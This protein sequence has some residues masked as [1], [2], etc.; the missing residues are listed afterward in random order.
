M[1]PHLP[2]LTISCAL[3][4][5]LVLWCGMAL[6]FETEE[7]LSYEPNV[8]CIKGSPYGK[9]L[10]LALQGPIDLY[11]H[12]GTTHE[13][14]TILGD[15][16]E[17]HH[18]HH[19]HEYHADDHDHGHHADNH[20]HGH[21][22]HAGCADDCDHGHDHAIAMQSEDQG[23][24]L[25]EWSKQKIKELE[26][27][28]HR[29]TDGKSLSLAHERYLQEETEAKL[30]LAYELDPAN[31]TNYANYHFFLSTNIGRNEG[32]QAASL[33]LA[34]KTLAY[35]KQDMFDPASWVTASSAAYNVAQHIYDHHDQYEIA[36]AKASL[37]EIDYC[38]RQY[39]CMLA[40]AGAEG[41]SVSASRLSQMNERMHFLAKLRKALG[42]YMKRAMTNQMVTH[43][44]IYRY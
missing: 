16:H 41:R 36:D 23:R 3:L 4:M 44:P 7:K 25:H 2:K 34:K 12:K 13:Y 28:A 19:D 37:A 9:V 18:G 27:T 29:K 39:E 43:T 22:H 5:G 26:A 1:N 8:A 30:R 38:M 14:S 33:H 15:N 32:D 21:H 6:K 31:H 10:A 35:C 11:W 24:S 40:K 20:S 42:V 17:H